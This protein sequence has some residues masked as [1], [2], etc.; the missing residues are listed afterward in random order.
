MD[1]KE[2]KPALDLESYSENS[3]IERLEKMG[4]FG[5]D[6]AFDIERE[7]NSEGE[8][9][10]AD[11]TWIRLKKPEDPSLPEA[12]AVEGKLY[13][14]KTSDNN[15]II[16]FTPGFPGGNAGRFEQRYAKTFTDAGY[17]FFT[18]RHNG[19]NLK[20]TDTAP[21]IL[22]SPK[23]MEIAGATGEIHIGGENRIYSPADIV[24]ESVTPLLAMS[25]KFKTIHLMGQSMG[26]ASNYN[27]VS[28]LAKHPE[29]LNKI[30]NIV[31]IAGYV[32]KDEHTEGPLWDGLKMPM[33]DLADYELG[34]IEK[35]GANTVRSKE[36]FINSMRQ[37][38]QRNSQTVVPEHIGNILIFSPN[39]PL[40][41][42]PDKTQ[43]DYTS[44][45]GPNTG[46]K[47]IIRDESNTQAPKQHS[48]LWIDPQNLLRA[49]QAEVSGHGPHYVKVPSQNSNSI[50]KG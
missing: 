33:E 50:E 10:N 6:F 25:S 23:R 13:L 26:V 20:K 44:H 36:D 3:A 45:Y 48:M 24:E 29:I 34:Y 1:H 2:N 12:L 31:G 21:E 39:D 18:I 8:E 32:G 7:Q 16:I 9:I 49:V 46:K 17:T 37:V 40:V 5:I 22:N 42:G 19:T 27:A 43:E 38:A 35:V 41:A 11:I 28:R 4:I 47:L 14:P 15:E 30:H